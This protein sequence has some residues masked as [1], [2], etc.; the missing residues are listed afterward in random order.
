MTDL[1]PA[2]G[3]RWTPDPVQYFLHTQRLGFRPWGEADLGLATGLWGDEKVTRL[4]GGLFSPE[5]VQ[6]RLALEISNLK[7]Y[8]VQYW[9]VFLLS[10]DEHVGCCGL[11]PYA[12]D[13]RVYEIGVH[14]RSAHW[15][16]G[17]ALEAAQGVMEYAFNALGATGLFAGH[18]PAND[19]S[20]RLL[21]KLGFSYTRDEYYPPTGLDHPSYVLTAADFACGRVSS[22][23]W[24]DPPGRRW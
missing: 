20:R 8:G 16:H 10:S 15:G 4:I 1:L 2:S 9:P 7:S 24:M 22:R 12:P 17:Y 21:G 14:I 13:R 6:A 23:Q 19:A 18:H 5:Q 3:D 11:R